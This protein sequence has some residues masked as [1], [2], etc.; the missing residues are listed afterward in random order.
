MQTW[1]WFTSAPV[2]CC[3][4]VSN[5]RSP[6]NKMRKEVLEVFQTSIHKPLSVGAKL[7]AS[8]PPP[9]R[10]SPSAL[11]GRYNWSDWHALRGALIF[12]VRVS[13]ISVSDPVRSNSLTCLMDRKGP[14]RDCS[15]CL[16]GFTLSLLDCVCRML[17]YCFVS[18]ARTLWWKNGTN[19][20][21]GDARVIKNNT[22]LKKTTELCW[23]HN[24]KRNGCL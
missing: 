8:S 11:A 20:L 9:R 14:R 18:V 19:V 6:L 10:F 2:T 3:C 13:G 21:I 23:K 4:P 17:R 22:L 5:Y 7:S 1:V 15:R 16:C 24:R 12:R